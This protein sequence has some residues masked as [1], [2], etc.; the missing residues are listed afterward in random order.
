MKPILQ[1]YPPILDEAESFYNDWRKCKILTKYVITDKLK[2]SASKYTS[3]SK[4]IAD[5][6]CD[7]IDLVDIAIVL[8]KLLNIQLHEKLRYIRVLDIIDYLYFIR[9]RNNQII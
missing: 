4:L 9:V 5:L 3:E 2:I 1:R 7:S 6:A 8:E